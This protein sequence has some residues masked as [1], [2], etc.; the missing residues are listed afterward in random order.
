MKVKMTIVTSIAR[1]AI[2]DV[3]EDPNETHERFRFC[4]GGTSAVDLSH[5]GTLEC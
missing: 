5:D 4:F 2:L 1:P 3:C